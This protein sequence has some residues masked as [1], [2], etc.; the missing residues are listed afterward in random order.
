[1]SRQETRLWTPTVVLLIGAVLSLGISRQQQM[2]LTK[3]LEEALP[4]SVLGIGGENVSLAEPVAAVAGFDDY[5][6]R[7]Y[8]DPN[9]PQTVTGPLPWVSVYVGFYGSQTQGHTI[10]SP[11]NCLP[12]A[13]W[14][15]LSSGKET[16]DIGG[17]GNTVNRY[18]LQNEGTR[19]MVLYWYQGRGRIAHNEYTVKWDLLRDA[20]LR[21]RTDEALVRIVVPVT[22]SE[23]ES[24]RH[25]RQVAET[26]APS[27]GE[28]LPH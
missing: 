14:E 17:E 22:N 6:L 8:G 15:A 2:E 21:R 26:L 13:G 20:A 10:H 25:A 1:M 11:R 24:I 16:L 12:G 18:L 28:A 7:V 19:A 3:P 9:A 5:A 27:V 4:D 23:A